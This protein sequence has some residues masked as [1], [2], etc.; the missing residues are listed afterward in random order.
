MKVPLPNADIRYIHDFISHDQSIE[1]LNAL[2]NSVGWQQN[3][4]RMFGKTYDEPRLTAWYGDSDIKY[5]YSGIK[6]TPTPWSNLLKE[7]KYKVDH[8]SNTIF[9]SALVNYYRDGQDSMGYHQDNE[10]ELGKNP[11]IASLTLGAERTFQLKHITD[12]AIKRKD[13]PLKSGSLLIMAGETQHYW[14]HQI[15]KTKK[16]IGPRLNITFR[17]IKKN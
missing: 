10:P 11:I 5:Q 2:L 3:K 8:I 9:N 6:L 15:P 13:I 1:Y 17:V 14:K 12:K 7:L 4:I 16:P